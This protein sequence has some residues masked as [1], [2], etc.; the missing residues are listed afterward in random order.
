MKIRYCPVKKKNKLIYFLKKNWAKKT[1]LFKNKSFFDW[2]YYDYNLKRYNF[3]I[4][5][6][7]GNVTSCLGILKNK[8]KI[9]WLSIWFSDI[10]KGNSGLDLLY[11]LFKNSKK[12]IIACN[13]INIKTIPIY[14]A[15]SFRVEFL[16]HFFLINP[17]IKKYKLI[18]VNK[19]NKQVAIKNTIKISIDNNL[20]FLKKSQYLKKFENKFLKDYDYY[21][22]KYFEHPIYRYSFYTI[23]K[24]KKIFGFFVGRVCRYKTSTCLRFVEYYGSLNIL[25]NIK[26]PLLKLIKET[27]HEYVDFYNLGID[28]NILKKAGFILNKFNDELVIPNYYEPFVK[29]NIKIC[30]IYWPK[31]SKLLVFKGD[32]DQDRPSKD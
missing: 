20:N 23:S 21:N 6:K 14:K 25:L 27:K 13:G 8:K 2:M 17:I 5:E 29:K 4:T 24:N 28:K 10:K 15:L 7:K 9:L 3:L 1:I 32:G 12:R 30:C 31:I 16:N 19:I 11:F 26:Y 18:K 22:Q